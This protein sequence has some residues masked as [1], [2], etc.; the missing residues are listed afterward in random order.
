MYNIQY[1]T[2]IR[3]LKIVYHYS[4]VQV[5]ISRKYEKYE[6]YEIYENLEKKKN[7]EN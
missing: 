1:R 7:Y 5:K 4:S 6:N 3:H 2:I